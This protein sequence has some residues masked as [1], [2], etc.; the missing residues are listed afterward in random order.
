MYCF[1]V[2]QSCKRADKYDP[3]PENI[4]LAR[5]QKVI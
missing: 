2:L 3:E 4:S 1:Y 5:T